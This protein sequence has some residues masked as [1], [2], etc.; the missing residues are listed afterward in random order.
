M[1]VDIR[2]SACTFSM[3]SLIDTCIH[4]FLQMKAT[5]DRAVAVMEKHGSAGANNK[6]QVSKCIKTKFSGFPTDYIFILTLKL[7]FF[8]IVD[9][10]Y[11]YKLKFVRY[12]YDCMRVI[13][14]IK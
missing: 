9:K 7:V 4:I 1:L 6:K 5:T 2:A 10:C 14:N 11:G 12:A 13:F 3:F 8:T